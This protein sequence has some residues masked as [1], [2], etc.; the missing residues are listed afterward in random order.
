MDEDDDVE[1][2][3]RDPNVRRHRASLPPSLPL[4]RLLLVPS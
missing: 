1:E 4:A 2:D 3:E